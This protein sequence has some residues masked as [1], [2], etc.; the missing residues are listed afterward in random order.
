MGTLILDQF[1]LA[2]ERNALEELLQV[3]DAGF[4]AR[5]AESG[6][7]KCIARHERTHER[8]QL[9][10]VIRFNGGAIGKTGSVQQLSTNGC[11]TSGFPCVSGSGTL[12]NSDTAA[13]SGSKSRN[14]LPMRQSVIS[15]CRS[16]W[17]LRKTRKLNAWS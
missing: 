14:R 9:G 12:A 15:P 17:C 4:D 3:R 5:R 10:K 1:L 13:N 16:G 11:E 6:G 8:L 7:G 2:R